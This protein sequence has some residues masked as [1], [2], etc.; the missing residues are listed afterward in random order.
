MTASLPLLQSARRTPAWVAWVVAALLLLQAAVPLLAA[1]AAELR[2]LSVVEVCSVYGMRAVAIDRDGQVDQAPAPHD[3]QA[4]GS[5][6]CVLSPLLTA[7][8]DHP[9]LAAVHLHAPAPREAA[10][11]APRILPP[12]ALRIW[13]AARKHGPPPLSA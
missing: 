6:H 3:T 10:P 4:H 5:E 7:A 12:D 2:G 11:A 9:P 13:Q 1:K 8:L